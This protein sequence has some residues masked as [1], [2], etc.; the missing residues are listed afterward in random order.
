[1]NAY[2]LPT[3]L[4]V[5]D[6]EGLL[7]AWRRLLAPSCV[8]VGAVVTGMA[9]L[10]A[11]KES[12]PDVVVLDNFLP[13]SIGVDLCSKILGDLAEREGRAGER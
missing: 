9:A 4:L 7:Q 13:D 11:V 5:D 12:R 8:I 3:V 2:L 6:H 1:M 10:A